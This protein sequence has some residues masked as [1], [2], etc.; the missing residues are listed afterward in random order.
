[1]RSFYATHKHIRLFVLGVP[2][3]WHIAA[4]DLG[5][6]KWLEVGGLTP[7]A[8]KDAKAKAVQEAAAILGRKVPELKWH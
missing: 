7:V 8:L 2:E 4:F 5:A 6:K 3:A 1:M